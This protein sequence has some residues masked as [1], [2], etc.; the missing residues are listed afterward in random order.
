MIKH[1]IS[2]TFWQSPLLQRSPCALC[3][4]VSLTLVCLLKYSS[5]F[6][7]SLNTIIFF[8]PHRTFHPSSRYLDFLLFFFFSFFVLFAS[9]SQYSLITLLA[10]LPHTFDSNW[11]SSSLFPLYS[12]AVLFFF[13]LMQPDF[14]FLLCAVYDSRT[15][16]LPD[17]NIFRRCQE[18]CKKCTASNIC[19][20]CKPGMR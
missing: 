8:Q 9:S 3:Q 10:G 19:T 18:N 7:S 2:I 14:W 5:R 12:P 13:F 4:S 1:V 20:E 11:Y 15:V 17:S 16:C 6:P